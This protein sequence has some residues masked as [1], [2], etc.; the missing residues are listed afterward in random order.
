M[1]RHAKIVISVWHNVFVNG[2][3]YA[4]HGELMDNQN[5]I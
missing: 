4:M 5:E 1:S 2:V 3:L